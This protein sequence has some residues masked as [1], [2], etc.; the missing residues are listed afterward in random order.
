M[1]KTS[2]GASNDTLYNGPSTAA[3]SEALHNQGP[4]R[5]V[6]ARARHREPNGTKSTTAPPRRH[7]QRVGRPPPTTPRPPRQGRAGRAGASPRSC[8]PRRPA[9]TAFSHGRLHG[10]GCISGPTGPSPACRGTRGRPMPPRALPMT[11]P[12][13]RDHR[14]EWATRRIE[15]VRR[16]AKAGGTAIRRR[17]RDQRPIRPAPA[18]AW[19]ATERAPASATRLD[20]S[21]GGARFSRATSP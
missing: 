17:C 8:S 15:L 18:Q 13:T 12:R 16:P 1:S 3:L 4:W 2:S 21:C 11:V 10:A 20:R 5:S 9:A 14:N 6:P 19:P 7:A